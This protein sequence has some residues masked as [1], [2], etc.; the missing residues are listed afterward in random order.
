MIRHGAVA[1][2]LAGSIVLGALTLAPGAYAAG[3]SQSRP[4]P[5]QEQMERSGRTGG[6]AGGG[7]SGAPC[8][9]L[10]QHVQAS[11]AGAGLTAQVA[12]AAGARA[13]QECKQGSLTK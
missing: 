10:R 8:Q 12:Q 5:A 6:G 11:Y 9:T 4:R 7:T 3:D 13:E 1:V 2:M